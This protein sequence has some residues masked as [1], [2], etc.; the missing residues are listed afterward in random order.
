MTLATP[1]PGLS[2]TR[3]IASGMRPRTAIPPMRRWLELADPLL[4]LAH[5][6]GGDHFVVAPDR[7]TAA[8]GDRP[9]PVASSLAIQASLTSVGAPT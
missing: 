8:L 6:G 9:P 3:S 1:G 5:R 4:E 7:F 2:R